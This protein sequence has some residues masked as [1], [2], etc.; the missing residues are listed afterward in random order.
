MSNTN[1]TLF[2]HEPMLPTVEI[3]KSYIPYEIQNSYIFN[4][5]FNAYGNKFDKLGLDLEDLFLQILPQTAGEW[6]ITLWEKRVGII[7]NTSKSITERRARVL[8]KLINKGITTV[9]VIKQ[10]CKIYFENAE[11][12]QHNPQYYFELNLSTQQ[13]F[14]KKMDGLYEAIEI[15]KP[16]HL[17]VNY[18]M[19]SKLQSNL[20]LAVGNMIGEKIIV[21]P[22]TPPK[23]KS[24]AKAYVPINNYIQL[25]KI[26][27]YPKEEN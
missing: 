5:I 3:L 25:E 24:E 15:V 18:K 23:I 21:Y 4:Q 8:A 12:I 19:V 1:V 11:V 2:P 6:G 22:W 16:A 10:I 17:G 7:T 9:W 26:K 14:T 20:Y 27:V 13:G